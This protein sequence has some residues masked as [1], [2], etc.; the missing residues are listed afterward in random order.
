MAAP[1]VAGAGALVR[2]LNPDLGARTIVRL[3]KETARRPAGTG[4]GP[5]L[6]WGIVDAA[7]AVAKAGTLDRRPPTSR[8]RRLP[9]RPA[10]S[11]IT[12]RWSGRDVP[13]ASVALSGIAR[14]ELWRSIDGR[15]ARRLL[16]TRRTTRRVTV[17]AGARYGF[18]TVAIDRAGNRE[19]KPRRPD[20]R[21]TL[22]A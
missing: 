11:T 9:R 21:L 4:W 13:R 17:R 16:T 2:N 5:E 1:M 22:P 14:Y 12:V 15:R 10:G 18:F 3:L 7:A 8:V 19:R 20:A 6:G